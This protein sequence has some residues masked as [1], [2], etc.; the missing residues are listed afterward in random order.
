MHCSVLPRLM[1]VVVA[2][3]APG[4]ARARDKRDKLSRSCPESDPAPASPH[5]AGFVCAPAL[6]PQ[7]KL[8]QWGDALLPDPIRADV[9]CHLQHLKYN[10]ETLEPPIFSSCSVYSAQVGFCHIQAPE[11]K[12]GF[13]Y[14]EDAS[15][16]ALQAQAP[17]S[18]TARTAPT[19]T[20][21]AKPT[22]PLPSRITPLPE[23]SHKNPTTPWRPPPPT[24]GNHKPH[25]P[26]Q[27]KPRPAP[28]PPPPPP[29]PQPSSVCA[30]HT[31]PQADQ[32]SGG[33]T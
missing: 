26:P 21:H 1:S 8:G 33:P 22:T 20:L 11:I 5:H 3:D 23:A 19:S 27:A 7:Q 6:P 32:S 13:P 25:N 24:H 12:Q 29:R 15:P 17:S 14:T 2:A 31:P 16:C 30:A 9:L 28:P 18:S 4:H 10:L